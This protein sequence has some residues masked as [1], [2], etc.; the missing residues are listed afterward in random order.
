LRSHGKTNEKKNVFIGSEQDL[1]VNAKRKKNRPPWQTK[2]K[3]FVGTGCV[4][5]MLQNKNVPT[6][7]GGVVDRAIRNAYPR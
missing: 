1:G 5:W 7:F 4:L 6:K 2:R 3:R